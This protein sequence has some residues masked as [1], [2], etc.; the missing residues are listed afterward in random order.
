MASLLV[1]SEAS[2]VLWTLFFVPCGLLASSF[3]RLSVPCF[4]VSV[5]DQIDSSVC[6][7]FAAVLDNDLDI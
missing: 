7:A 5:S 4:C 3:F 2:C 1:R 6:R